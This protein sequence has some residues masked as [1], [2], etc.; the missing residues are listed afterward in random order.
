[1]TVPYVLDKRD[2]VS[3]FMLL[4]GKMMANKIQNK[5]YKNLKSIVPP[6]HATIHCSVLQR[7]SESTL[8]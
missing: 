5:K 3:E 2:L 7:S 8:V 4:M 1:M 6:A